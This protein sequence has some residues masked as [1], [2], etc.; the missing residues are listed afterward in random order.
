MNYR[1]DKQEA[2]TEA[3]KQLGDSGGGSALRLCIEGV[4]RI[5]ERGDVLDERYRVLVIEA[6]AEVLCMPV[7]VGRYPAP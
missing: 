7:Q 1:T 2:L 4:E 5:S 3:A 6:V